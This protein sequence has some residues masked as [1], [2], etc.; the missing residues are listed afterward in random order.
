MNKPAAPKL[1]ANLSRAQKHLK[2]FQARPALHVI[3][4]E[5]TA[6]RSGETFESLDP[7]SNAVLCRVAS[8]N[9]EDI[10][11]AAIAAAAAFEMWSRIPGSKRRTILH[12]IADNIVARAEEIALIESSDTGQP[13]RYMSKAALRGAEN[14]RFFADRAPNARDGLSL[15]DEHHL[16]YTLRQPIGPVGIITPWNTPFMLSTWKI[17]PALAAGCTVVHKPAEWSPVTADLL[18]KLVK[19]AGVPD[20]VFNTVHGFGEEAGRAL[21]EHPAIKAIGFVG[22]RATGS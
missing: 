3:A 5:A 4:G 10:D 17:A 2:R 20:G 19:Q 7:T 12:A 18:A 11:R 6:S 16:N 22:E 21:T 8:G 15:P 14:F 1:A 13:I 9:A